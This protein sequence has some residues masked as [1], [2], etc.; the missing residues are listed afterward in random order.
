MGLEWDEVT[1]EWRR[2]YK[3]ELYDLYSWVFKS[4]RMRWAGHVARMRNRRSAHRFL[5]GDKMERDHLEDIR[6]DGSIVLKLAFK[7]WD[8]EMWA[9]II[10]LRIGAGDI[11]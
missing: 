11:R 6:I 7:E 2:L 1:G 8:R 3:E 9:G 5:V 10:W 4:R